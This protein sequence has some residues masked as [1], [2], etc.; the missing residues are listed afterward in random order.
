MKAKQGRCER[1]KPCGFYEGEQATIE[2]MR[3]LKAEGLGFDRIAA[4]L[5]AEG[6]ETR[7]RGSGTGSW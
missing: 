7:R 6:I 5:N 1:R 3:A 4:R 2:R